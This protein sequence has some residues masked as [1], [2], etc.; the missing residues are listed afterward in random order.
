MPNPMHLNLVPEAP[1]SLRACLSKVHRAYAGHI[2]ARE[3]RTGHFWQVRFGCVAMDEAHLITPQQS[4]ARKRKQAKCYRSTCCVFIGITTA[5]NMAPTHSQPST[6]IVGKMPL[7]YPD[8]K[9]MA[10]LLQTN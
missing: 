1:D 4:G 10:A 7:V 5:R 6:P 8:M 9:G 2:H 3:Q